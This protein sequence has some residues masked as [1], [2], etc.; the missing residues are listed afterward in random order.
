[1][2][3]GLTN[4]TLEI[5]V[6]TVMDKDDDSN[7]SSDI[8]SMSPVDDAD[9]DDMFENMDYNL[10]VINNLDAFMASAVEAGREKGINAI[11]HQRSGE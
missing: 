8:K 10:N 9:I 5:F 2:S 11:K 7:D 1:M 6:E 3:I 4:V